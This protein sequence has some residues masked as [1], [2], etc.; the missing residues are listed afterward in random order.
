MPIDF[1]NSLNATGDINVFTVQDPDVDPNTVLEIDQDWK[2]KATWFVDSPNFA[3]IAGGVWHLAINIESMGQG[4]EKTL[5]NVDVAGNAPTSFN[6][7]TGHME[8]E[9]VV[10]IPKR[11]PLVT[12]P[13]LT[14]NQEGIYKLVLVLTYTNALGLVDR[15]AGFHEGLMVQFYDF[16]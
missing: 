3:Y 16:A 7:L 14:I 10:T 1:K 4:Q 15:I 12:P 8:Y 11:D 5:A 2:V 6:P 13:A 9:K